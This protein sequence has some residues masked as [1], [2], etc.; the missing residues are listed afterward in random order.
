MV[1]IAQTNLGAGILSEGMYAREDTQKFRQGLKDA[2]NV[3]V[4]TQGGVSNRAGLE[5][6]TGIDT[7]GAS[8]EQFLVPFSFNDE[9]TYQ[10]E[11]TDSKFRII[12]DGGYVLDTSVTAASVSGVTSATTAEITLSDAADAADFPAGVLA[13]LEDPNGTHALHNYG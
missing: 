13:Y 10:V 11:F 2:V 7:S 6:V 5:L 4:R 12:R 3:F 8:H 9:Q 1:R